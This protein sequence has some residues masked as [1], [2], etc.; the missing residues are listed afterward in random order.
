MT[1]PGF[2]HYCFWLHVVLPDVLTTSGGFILNSHLI[3]TRFGRPSR[4]S[5]LVRCWLQLPLPF[6]GILAFLPHTLVYSFLV[7]LIPPSW[8]WL[9]VT[10]WWASSSLQVRFN[11]PHT[12]HLSLSLRVYCELWVPSVAR[13]RTPAARCVGVDREHNVALMA[14]GVGEHHVVADSVGPNRYGLIMVPSSNIP[15][16]WASSLM[17]GITIPSSSS[18]WDC[19]YSCAKISLL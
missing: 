9:C 8:F 17:Q 5:M 3:T 6:Q 1:A 12:P 2:F 11:G 16:S 10:V 18:N 15:S 19:T 13:Y 4:F 7:N 14:I